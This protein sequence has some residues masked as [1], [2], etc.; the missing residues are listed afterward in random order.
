MPI[1]KK[2]LEDFKVLNILIPNLSNT[3][4]EYNIFDKNKKKET[5]LELGIEPYN[6]YVTLSMSNTSLDN[7]TDGE[8]VNNLTGTAGDDENNA[9]Q[10]ELE[11]AEKAEFNA[12]KVVVQNSPDIQQ[13]D[14]PDLKSA[15]RSEAQSD[16]SVVNL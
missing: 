5:L 8:K 16:I 1:D 2:I 7:V 15:T 10:K 6:N 3:N 11:N 4:V 12:S 9:L 14:L 13:E